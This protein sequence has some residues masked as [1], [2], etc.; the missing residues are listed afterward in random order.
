MQERERLVEDAGARRRA[1]L[2]S[3]F[4][5]V[6]IDWMGVSL[7]QPIMPF[8]ITTVL[9]GPPWSVGCLYAIYASVQ[10]VGTPLL[11]A[12]SDR[13]GRRPVMIV[14]LA[15]TSGGYA[16]SALAWDYRYLLAAR[17]MQGFFSS[18]LSVANSYIADVL[19]Q[20]ERPAVMANLR[21]LGSATCVQPS[22]RMR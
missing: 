5:A 4:C 1:A 11:G 18:S 12:A 22:N 6:V 9:G 2:C 20:S 16:L 3:V 15:G 19:P 17:G 21:G 14:S 8:Y 13:W 10:I 7:T